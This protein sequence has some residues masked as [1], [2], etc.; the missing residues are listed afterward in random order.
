MAGAGSLVVR[1]ARACALLLA[2]AAPT[3]A[4]GARLDRPAATATPSTASLRDARDALQLRVDSLER[5]L[6]VAR[7]AA[8]PPRPTAYDAAV[9]SR[10]F[11]VTPDGGS[12]VAVAL[13]LDITSLDVLTAQSGL[14][15]LTRSCQTIRLSDTQPIVAIHTLLE[16][17]ALRCWS[18]AARDSAVPACW[19]RPHGR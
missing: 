14:S 5:Q 19:S 2:I 11:A 13:C 18:G 16:H 17:E 1:L 7:S 15:H 12:A 8:P 6:A 3:V 10:S 4:C 9:V